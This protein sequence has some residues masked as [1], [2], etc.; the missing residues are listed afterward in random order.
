MHLYVVFFGEGGGDEDDYEDDDNDRSRFDMNDPWQADTISDDVDEGGGG[1]GHSIGNGST[2][3]VQVD[4]QGDENDGEGAEEGHEEDDDECYDE[5]TH[6]EQA[7]DH[8]EGNDV[9]RSQNGG[10]FIRSFEDGVDD[11]NNS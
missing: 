9:D 6:G 1:V 3:N 11:D 2:S 10:K 5:S 8:S 4:S 7:E